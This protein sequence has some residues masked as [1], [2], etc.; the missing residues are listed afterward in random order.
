MKRLTVF[1]CHS[2][3]LVNKSKLYNRMKIEESS[4]AF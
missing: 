4:D 2:C 3:P 1:D